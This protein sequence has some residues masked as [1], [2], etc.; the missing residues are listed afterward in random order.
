MEHA[1]IKNLE[2][3]TGKPLMVWIRICKECGHAKHGQIV[4]FLKTDYGLT[5]GYANLIAHKAKGS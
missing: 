5:D 2:V 1:V 4:K 3:K